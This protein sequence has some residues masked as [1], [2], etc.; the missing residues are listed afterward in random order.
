MLSIILD[1]IIITLGWEALYVHLKS[2]Y[3]NLVEVQPFVQFIRFY[4]EFFLAV[5]TKPFVR[6][7][8]I[9]NATFHSLHGR[10]LAIKVL[11]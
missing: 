5:A 9:T 6:P 11:A 10:S 8:P 7:I 1:N 2:E 4:N 3:T